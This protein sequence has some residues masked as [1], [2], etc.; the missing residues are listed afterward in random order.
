MYIARSFQENDI[1]CPSF[2][3][4]ACKLKTALDVTGLILPL[5]TLSTISF[6]L[7]LL[8][9]SVFPGY[10]DCSVPPFREIGNRYSG[11]WIP[12]DCLI[13]NSSEIV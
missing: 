6:L 8:S 5:V 13:A 2:V 4:I 3:L 10:S 11:A 7:S 12:F 1:K 9:K